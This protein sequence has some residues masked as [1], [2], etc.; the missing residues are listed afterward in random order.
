MSFRLSYLGTSSCYRRL[1][2]AQLSHV[3]C[4]GHWLSPEP[5]LAKGLCS[6]SQEEVS[7]CSRPT[8]SLLWSRRQQLLYSCIKH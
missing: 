8:L 5:D 4:K 1:S 7:H 3:S 6:V 2:Q